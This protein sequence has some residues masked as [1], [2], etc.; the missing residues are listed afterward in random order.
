MRTGNN[1]NKSVVS[2][3]QVKTGEKLRK[4]NGLNSDEL[5]RMSRGLY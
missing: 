2:T 4:I 1:K 5:Y 3:T